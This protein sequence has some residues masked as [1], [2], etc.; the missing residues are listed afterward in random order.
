M[1]NTV[2][3]SFNITCGSGGIKA[4]MGS[5]TKGGNGNA[6]NWLSINQ[7]IT[8]NGSIGGSA[9]NS[10]TAN[11]AG[12]AGAV[13]ADGNIV[14]PPQLDSTYTINY[15]PSVRLISGSYRGYGKLGDNGIIYSNGRGGYTD[16]TNVHNDTFNYLGINILSSANF[17]LGT[18]TSTGNVYTS[19]PTYPLDF[20]VGCGT[21][22]RNGTASN[23]AIDGGKGYVRVYY[24]FD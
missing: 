19:I 8:I 3:N 16:C 2:S 11:A 13:G 18:S 15:N 24:L 22:T 17:K 10:A 23:P 6:T 20:G 7:N 12:N 9:G 21:S 4:N 1:I 14:G 5:I